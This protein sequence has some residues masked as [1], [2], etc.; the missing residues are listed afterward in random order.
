MPRATPDLINTGLVLM[1]RMPA[2]RNFKLASMLSIIS[3]LLGRRTWIDTEAELPR[4]YPNL[5]ILLVAPPGVGK[6]NAIKWATQ[7]LMDTQEAV[8]PRRIVSFSGTSISPKGIYD[9]LGPQSDSEQ[10][11]THKGR[12]HTF[13]SLTFH[14]PE[15]STM[16]TEYDSRLIGILNDLYNCSAF[17]SDR[18][19]GAEIIIPNPHITLLIGNQPATLYEVLP[20]KSFHMGF[21][22]RLCIFQADTRVKRRLFNVDALEDNTALRE[23]LIIDLIDVSLMSGPFL[24]T[25]N[26]GEWLNDFEDREPNQVPGPRWSS[27]NTRRILHLQKLAM[28]CSASERSDRVLNVDH[29]ERAYEIMTE[30]ERDLPTLFDGIISSKGFTQSYEQF[31]RIVTTHGKEVYIANAEGDKMFSHYEI[32][33]FTL[34]KELSKTHSMPEKEAILRELL[35][36]GAAVVQMDTRADPPTPT[37]PRTYIVRHLL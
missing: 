6:D 34:A 23:K 21:P 10:V 11:Y 27:Y 20:E 24:L 1:E 3:S 25:Y 18:I 14:I 5:Y 4:A 35:T 30:Y 33:H 36:S 15:M 17:A 2:P 7:I 28:I 19:R 16:M 29:I 32:S 13:R 9:A 26:A 12:V 8:N 37:Y 31:N 22:S